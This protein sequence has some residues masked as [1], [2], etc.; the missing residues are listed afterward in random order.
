MLQEPMMA[1]MHENTQPELLDSVAIRPW[2]LGADLGVVGAAAKVFADAE[3]YQ[4]QFDSN[5]SQFVIDKREEAGSKPMTVPSPQPL[6]PAERARLERVEGVIFDVQRYSLHDGPGLRT[7]VFIKGCS[8]RCEWCANPESHQVQPELAL[9]ANRCITCGQFPES[10]P[11]GWTRWA[12][13]ALSQQALREYG[14]RAAMCPTGAMRWLGERRTAGEIIADVLRD[15][16]FYLGNG[17][18]TLTGGEPTVQPHLAEALLRLAKAE[19]LSTAMETCG[20]TH[21]AV[22]EQLLPYLDH[23]LYDLKHVDNE[24]HRRHTGVGNE[25]ILSNLRRL[26]ALRVPLT[27]RVPLIPGCNASPESMRAIAG[28]VRQL[29]GPIGSIDLLPY[30]TLGKAKYTALGRDY[31]WEERPRLRETDVEELV[32]IVE[33]CGLRVNIGG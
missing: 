28:F 33:E 26:A 16:P 10:C 19:Y 20:H 30:H 2:Q 18:L 21:W 23:V 7:N 8:L 4:A 24:L 5:S 13:R 32:E 31:A 3:D 14:I 22:L 12:D 1:A 9:F 27:I 6:S 11:A 17:G 29:Q 15:A 25:L